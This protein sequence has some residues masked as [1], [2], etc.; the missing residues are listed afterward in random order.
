MNY[1]IVCGIETHIEL[2]TRTKIFCGCTTEFGGEPNTHCCPVC[3]GQP[4][5]LPVLNQKVVEYAIKAGLALNCKINT[6]SHMDRKNYVYPDLP[7]AYQ[8]SQYDEPLCEKGYIELDSGKRIG[9]ARI[10][11]EEDAGK[12][13]HEKGY[14]F[15]DYNRSGVPLIEIVSEPDISSAEEAKEYAEKLQLIMR[16]IG[17]SDCKMQEGSMRCDVNL[18]L[19]KPGDSSLGVRTE[20]KNI[21]SLSFIQKA[22]MAEAER[23]AD[24]LDA[25]GTVVQQTMR[26]DEATNTVT[27]MRDKENS[28]DYRYFPDPDIL[29]FSIDEEKIEEIRKS[30]PE[31]PFEKLKRY[32]NVLGLPEATAKQISRYRKVAE[33]FEGALAEG[34]SVKNAANLIV[35]T[36]FATMGTEEEKELFDVL[37]S[38]A[39]YAALVKLAD[40]RKIN[41]GVAQ[42]TLQKMLETGKP[43]EEFIKPEDLVGISD[44]ELEKLCREAM[45]A[46]P[47]AAADVR[48]G[49]DKAI[50]AMFGYIMKKTGGKADIRKAEVML[51]K[52]I[53]Q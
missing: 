33:F 13:I 49:K 7:K 23:Q 12:L 16:Y 46:N 37:I 27:P 28:E 30:L 21:N 20:I 3:T 39:Q 22:V 45:D 52:L 26:Y 44:E 29:R 50:N 42:A 47:K 41:I 8:I 24:I 1:E 31:L 43:V 14:T 10:H 17:I 48:S 51:R 19:R 25:G 34:A 38:P 53:G 11:I 15:I 2:A 40:E 6:K 4:G 18:S 36:I 9:I 35:G 32:V 5:A